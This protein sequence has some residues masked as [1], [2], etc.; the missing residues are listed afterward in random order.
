MV[1]NFD[2]K[3]ASNEL[4][5]VTKIVSWKPFAH[6]QKEISNLLAEPFPGPFGGQNSRWRRQMLGGGWRKTYNIFSTF[7]FISDQGSHLHNFNTRL[8]LK[9]M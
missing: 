7:F 8:N 4:E 2:G 9:I 6:A 1:L 3:L 5:P